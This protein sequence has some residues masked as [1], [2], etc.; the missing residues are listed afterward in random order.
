MLKYVFNNQAAMMTILLSDET[1]ETVNIFLQSTTILQFTIN[2]QW[3]YDRISF[4]CTV[5][6]VASRHSPYTIYVA[7]GKS[8]TASIEQIAISL[9]ALLMN[10]I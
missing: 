10:K 7:F 2:F 1:S 9:V 6:G 4:A 3:H 5:H 8:V